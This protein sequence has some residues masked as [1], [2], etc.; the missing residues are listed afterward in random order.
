MTEGAAFF[1]DANVALYTIGNDNEFRLSCLRIL[2]AAA[3]GRL[4]AVTDAEVIQ[5]IVYQTTGR[6]RRDQGIALAERFMLTVGT[7]PAHDALH[8]AIMRRH[9]LTHMITADRHFA[10][11]SDVTVLDPHA[12]AAMLGD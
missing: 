5:E 2:T 9:G 8:L 7:V 4:E 6:G 12:A 3:D 1:L 10:G 11:L